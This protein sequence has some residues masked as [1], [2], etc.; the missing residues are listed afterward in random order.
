[1]YKNQIKS[2]KTLQILYKFFKNH[3]TL[4]NQTLEY[5]MA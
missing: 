5:P 4:T 2:D 3:F 1:M